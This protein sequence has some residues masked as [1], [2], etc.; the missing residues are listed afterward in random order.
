[1]VTTAPRLAGLTRPH[2]APVPQCGVEV[3]PGGVRASLGVLPLIREIDGFSF[4]L[5]AP[6]WGR[7]ALVM[8]WRVFSEF[9][10]L[11]VPLLG[12]LSASNNP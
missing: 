6:D 2:K 12:G 11:E 7:L 8:A 4:P 10:N 5:L 1:V 9:L 3:G